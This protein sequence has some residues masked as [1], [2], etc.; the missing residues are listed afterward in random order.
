M[1]RRRKPSVETNVSPRNL[2]VSGGNA[3]CGSNDTRSHAPSTCAHGC[4]RGL[5]TNNGSDEPASNT[6]AVDGYFT[7]AGWSDVTPVP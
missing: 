6:V 3:F 1:L 7:G 4:L 2:T 5:K